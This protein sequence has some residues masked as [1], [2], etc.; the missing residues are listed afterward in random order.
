M[1]N[2]E[3]YIGYLPQAPDKTG[4][5]I[6]NILVFVFIVISL[7]GI[8]LASQQRK[9]STAVFEYG[10]NKEYTGIYTDFPIPS[11]KVFNQRDSLG[12]LINLSIPIVGYGKHGAKS[13]VS[14]FEERNA[15]RLNHMEVTFKGD[16]IFNEGKTL[17]SL[18]QDS[19]IVRF[20]IAN[21][22]PD[23]L[24]YLKDTVLSGEIIDPKCYF[25]VMKPGKGKVH[26]EC[27]IRC[28]SGGIPP[29]FRI[30][31]SG[32]MNDYFILLGKN[33]EE[34]NQQVLPYVADHILV[35]GKLFIWG[36][37]SV[38]QIDTE[39]ILEIN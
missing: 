13:A 25:G 4:K 18:N 11:I 15:I 26:R 1:K 10:S 37:W 9:F 39:S 34:I 19:P 20:S 3:F 32:T 31:K 22:L 33:G 17:L 12:K 24:V 29:V 14:A 28:I 38:F 8:L 7:A 30:K 16:L 27:A 36:N 35:R 21:V 2:E 23:Q 5:F 6:R